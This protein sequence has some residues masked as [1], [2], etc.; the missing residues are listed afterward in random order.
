M[1]S[2]LPSGVSVGMIPGNRPEDAMYEQLLDGP[3]GDFLFERIHEI[4]QVPKELQTLMERYLASVAWCP[5]CGTILDNARVPH[6]PYKGYCSKGCHDTDTYDP[7][8]N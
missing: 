1:A 3:F 4:A 5:F 8:G 2:N 6:P 7:E